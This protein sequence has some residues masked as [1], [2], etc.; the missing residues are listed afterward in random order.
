MHGCFASCLTAVLQEG[1]KGTIPSCC[2]CQRSKA[3]LRNPQLTYHLLELQYFR[4]IKT[5]G[6]INFLAEHVAI[7]IKDGV[8]LEKRGRKV[9]T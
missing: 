9:A 1:Y 2:L 6:N 4:I 3:L 8:L 5:D 7:P